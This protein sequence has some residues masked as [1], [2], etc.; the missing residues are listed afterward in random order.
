M[1]IESIFHS[2]NDRRKERRDDLPVKKY[3]KDPVH[4][5]LMLEREYVR[6][7]NA[8][9]IDRMLAKPFIA[10]LCHSG[11]GINRLV[12]DPELP[13]FATASYDGKVSLWDMGTRKK[14]SEQCFESPVAGIAIDHSQNIYVPQGR[15]ILGNGR[16]YEACSTVNGL[17]FTGYSSGTGDLGVSTDD[18]I[19]IFDIS[20]ISPKSTYHERDTTAIKFNS[21]FRH[22]MGAVSAGGVSLYDNRACKEFAVV[23]APGTNSMEFNP[24]Q[25]FVFATGNEDGNGYAYD[26]RN[27]DKPVG[28]YRGHV[29]AVVAV[30]FS[31]NGREIATG[32]FDRTIRIFGTQDRK[33]R[34]CYYNDRMQIVHGVAYSNDGQFIISGS[35]DGCLRLWKA[36]ASKKTGPI[37]RV[38][39][40]SLRYKEALKAKFRDVGDVARISRHRFLPKELKQQAKQRHEMYE[41]QERRKARMEKQV[42]DEGKDD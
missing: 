14:I 10:A 5:P 29:N 42:E 18:S 17:D 4:H 27:V 30:A 31:P 40:E 37:S 35:D 11:E 1:K 24:Q 33:S 15:R 22:L 26:I 25:G 23:A 41:A 34:D 3:S 7:L 38:E 19:Q 36:S 16:E 12:K 32:S 39:Q 8:T 9:K 6:A 28:T 20:R 21:S 13:F 2:K